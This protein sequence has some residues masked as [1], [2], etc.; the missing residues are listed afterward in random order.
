MNNSQNKSNDLTERFNM[1][2]RV[3]SMSQTT[4]DANPV[5]W[6]LLWD[7]SAVRS[8]TAEKESERGRFDLEFDQRGNR[9]QLIEYKSDGGIH[10]KT[11]WAY[12]QI[13]TL[14]EEVRHLDGRIFS[15]TTYTYTENGNLAE[16]TY[17]KSDGSKVSRTTHEYDK[18]GNEVKMIYYKSVDEH[19]AYLYNHD[20]EG[21]VKEEFVIDKSGVS[22][23][24]YTYRWDESG[25][26]IEETR[27]TPEGD[28]QYQIAYSYDDYGN[29]VKEVEEREEEDE[30]WIQDTVT[31][32]FE[33]DDIGN[34]ITRVKFT[35][36]PE[37]E[38]SA[39]YK[40]VAT[41]VNERTHVYFD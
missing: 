29:R 6:T 36:V 1:K 4:F 13:G 7:G 35:E 30:G 11:T 14:S 28:M 40:T 3:K 27:Y 17:S 16:E 26:C 21:N 39:Y 9:L 22:L 34:W 23:G 18:S 37:S 41:E 19:T 2:G 15:K 24:R 38:G 32:K 25:R 5:G 8:G 12:H 31:Y 33:Y 20:M 10:S